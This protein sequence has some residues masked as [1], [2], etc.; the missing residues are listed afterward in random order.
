MAKLLILNCDDF[1]QS[2]PANEAIMHLLEE[3][4]VSSATIMTPAQGFDQA[5]D[6]CRR[7]PEASV[8]LHLTFTSEYDAVR[9]ASLTGR[10][11]LHDAEGFMYKTVEAFERGSAKADVVAEMNAQFDAV[12]RAGIAVTHADNHMGS[13]YGIAAGRSYLP[14]VFWQCSRMGLPFRLFRHIDPAEALTANAPGV[15]AT[16]AKAVALCDTLGVAVPDYLLSHPYGIEPGETYES[17]K[18]MLIAKLYKL[19]EGVVETYI[20]PAVPDADLGARIPNWEKRVWEYKL[21]L[22]PDFAAAMKDA[23][24]QLT[25]YRYVREKLRRPRLGSAF[26]LAKL[27]LGRG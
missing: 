25:D 7:H 15:E 10:P 4:R 17:F 11:S 9:F 26:R 3:R 18:A 19:P 5:A 2:A 1:G 14:Q 16:L 20:H 23:G 24:V 8:G 6:W 27:A 13:L 22:D 21:M 12:A